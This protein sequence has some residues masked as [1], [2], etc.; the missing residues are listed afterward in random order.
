VDN[1]LRLARSGLIF[2]GIQEGNPGRVTAGCA[3]PHLDKQRRV[4]HTM[5]CHAGFRWGGRGSG[6]SLAAWEGT[7]AV[8]SGRT[9]LWVVRFVLCF[10]LIC[11]I[12]VPVPFVCCSV[13][14]PLSRPT[15]FLPGSFYSPWH[16]G[17]GM[18][19][20]VVL[21]LPAAAKQE[22]M[23]SDRF[24]VFSWFCPQMGRSLA[25]SMWHS[26]LHREGPTI[27]L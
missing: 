14:L 8:R 10:L 18:G 3:D 15:S 25:N 6:N 19:G 12:V 2:T 11:T 4:F 1:V 9:A 20:Y 16:P 13:K 26:S 22:H 23:S 27:C 21:L 17:G 5:C 24:C 7:A